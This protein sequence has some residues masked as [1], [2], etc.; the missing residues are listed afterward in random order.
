MNGKAVAPHTSKTVQH[1]RL[2]EEMST[3]NSVTPSSVEI[4]SEMMNNSCSEKRKA[5]SPQ[6]IDT[7]T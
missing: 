7:S 4:Q 1:L 6:G 2:T 5:G 3:E